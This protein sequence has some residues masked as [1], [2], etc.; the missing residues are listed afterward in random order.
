MK[1]HEQMIKAFNVFIDRVNLEYPNMVKAMDKHM[2]KK[3]FNMNE[4]LFYTP[5]RVGIDKIQNKLEE[6]KS[7]DI[8]KV[9][10]KFFWE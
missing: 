9:K 3:F 1:L 4:F 5:E 10:D 2:A 6:I 7:Y 8:S